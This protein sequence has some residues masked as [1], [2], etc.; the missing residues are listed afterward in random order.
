MVPE[1]GADVMAQAH[2]PDDAYR[3]C[4]EGELYAPKT[5]NKKELNHKSW[6][7][8]RKGSS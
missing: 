6:S 3:W 4:I 5:E 8:Y 2:P 7:R 1:A